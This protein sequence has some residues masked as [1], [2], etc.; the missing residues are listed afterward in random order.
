MLCKS[1]SR[2]STAFLALS[3][4]PE[5]RRARQGAHIQQKVAARQGFTESKEGII[6]LPAT[7]T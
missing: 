6:F 1:F 4:P 3:S 5:P 2:I 7:M